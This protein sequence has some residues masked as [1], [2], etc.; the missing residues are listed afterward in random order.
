MLECSICL[1][2]IEITCQENKISQQPYY[3]EHIFHTECISQWF[4]NCPN[5]RSEHKRYLM[6]SSESIKYNGN[7]YFVGQKI[8]FKS[9]NT[10]VRIGFIYAIETYV[11][12]LYFTMETSSLDTLGSHNVTGGVMEMHQIAKTDIEPL[13]GHLE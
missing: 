3:C 4:G 5:C 8:Y 11:D 1:E 7:F 12:G 9:Y 6:F 2:P 13:T 10:E